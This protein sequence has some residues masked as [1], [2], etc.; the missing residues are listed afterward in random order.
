MRSALRLKR[1]NGVLV[2]SIS[3]VSS[4]NI[5]NIFKSIFYSKRMVSKFFFEIGR[6]QWTMGSPTP[7]D[8]S[9]S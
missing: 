2:K 7:I 1:C 8:Q 3:M 6:D 9:T 4:I 5:S